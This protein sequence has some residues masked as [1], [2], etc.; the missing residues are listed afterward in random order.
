VTIVQQGPEENPHAFLQ[1]LK[2][3]IRKHTTVDPESQGGEALLN[4]FLTQAAPDICR[5]LQ[6]SVAEGEKIIGQSNMTSHVCILIT[7][8]SLKREKRMRKHH[9]LIAAL[10]EGPT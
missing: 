6:K 2:D 3:A 7:R 9:D 10:R 1:H 5:K 4:K 8:T